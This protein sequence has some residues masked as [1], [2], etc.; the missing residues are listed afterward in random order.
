MEHDRPAPQV[1]ENR[2]TETTGHAVAFAQDSEKWNRRLTKVLVALSS[3]A[4]VHL[5][6][7]LV[8]R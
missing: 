2:A 5:A 4:L 6:V 1:E 3:V 8:T 7:D